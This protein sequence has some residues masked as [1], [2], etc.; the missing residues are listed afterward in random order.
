[1]PTSLA[2]TGNEG[3]EEGFEDQYGIAVAGQTATCDG[4]IFQSPHRSSARKTYR[5]IGNRRTILQ[6]NQANRILGIVLQHGHITVNTGDRIQ[7]TVKHVTR[8]RVV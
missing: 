6:I 5:Q 3:A 4:D 1:M 7:R 2:L 8:K